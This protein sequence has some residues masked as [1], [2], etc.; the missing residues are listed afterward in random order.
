MVSKISQDFSKIFQKKEKI[1]KCT[2]AIKRQITV[3]VLH[4]LHEDNSQILGLAFATGWVVPS[5]NTSV[6]LICFCN[7]AN[8]V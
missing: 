8:C 2:K 3:Q 6:N 5:C 1:R 7:F 4:I